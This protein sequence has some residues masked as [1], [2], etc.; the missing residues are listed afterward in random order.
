MNNQPKRDPA[1]LKEDS[2]KQAEVQDQATTLDA[3]KAILAEHLELV[4]RA[5]RECSVSPRDLTSGAVQRTPLPHEIK[6][7]IAQLHTMIRTII[8]SAAERIQN[9][10]YRSLEDAI[11]EKYQVV[12][13]KERANAFIAA[14][15]QVNTSV[16]ALRLTVSHFVELN[17]WILE[18][19]KQAQSVRNSSMAREFV[20]A[21]AILVYELC[22]FVIEYIEH[23]QI[24]GFNELQELK[25]EEERS[26]QQFRQALEMRKKQAQA[27]GI[28]DTQRQ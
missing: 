19:L 22:D 13:Q 16:Y 6:E 12:Q 5:V 15:K 1:L 24:A 26:R 23:F 27:V 17:R 7:G 21:N 28:C 8:T 10:R 25:R 14:E 4:I 9:R 2:L 20:L 18:R 11:G 3:N